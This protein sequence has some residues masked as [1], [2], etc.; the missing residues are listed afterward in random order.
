M[1]KRGDCKKK[2]TAC[3]ESKAVLPYPYPIVAAAC[4]CNDAADAGDFG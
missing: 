3:C 2:R 4:G 1:Y